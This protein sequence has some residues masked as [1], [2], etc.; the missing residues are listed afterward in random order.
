MKRCLLH[1]YLVAPVHNFTSTHVTYIVRSSGI[2]FVS[3]LSATAQVFTFAY[4]Q[5]S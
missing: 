3:L 4:E 1:Q 2:K 5:K